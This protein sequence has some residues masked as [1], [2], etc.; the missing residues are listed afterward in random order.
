MKKVVLRAVFGLVAFVLLTAVVLLVLHRRL[1]LSPWIGWGIFLAWIVKLTAPLF[2]VFGNEISGRDL[3]LIL[4]GLFLL[5]K[6]THEIRRLSRMNPMSPEATVSRTYLDCLA[7]LPWT[8]R[9]PDRTDLAEAR[10]DLA[11]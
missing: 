3:I 7:A 6:A 8:E 9:T 10:D 1:S 2:E 11:N 5:A 4:G